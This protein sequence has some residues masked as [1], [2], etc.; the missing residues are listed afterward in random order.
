MDDLIAALAQ[1]GF[2]TNSARLDDVIANTLQDNQY[3]SAGRE[4]VRVLLKY[5]AQYGHLTV[6]EIKQKRKTTMFS[7][8]DDPTP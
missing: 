4:N 7:S 2:A 3:S 5:D 6:G 8:R 1:N